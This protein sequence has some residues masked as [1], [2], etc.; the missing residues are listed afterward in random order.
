MALTIW[1]NYFLPPAANK[2]F[3]RGVASYRLL[4][5]ASMS[6]CNLAAG[7]S[8]PA[9][10]EAEIIFGQ[11]DP[12]ALFD[13]PKLKWVHLTSAGYDRYDRPDLRKSFA[14]RGAV[15]TNSSAVYEEPCAQHVLA[16][17]LALSRRLPQCLDEQRGDRSW[18]AAK[19]RVEAYRLVGQ[20]VVILSYG[21]IARRLIE[22]LLPFR[23]NVIAVRRQ[24]RDDEKVKTVT[25]RDLPSVL[26]LADH[27]VNILPGGAETQSAMG[28]LMFSKMKRGANF[29]NIGRGSTVDQSALLAALKSEQL[30]AAYLDV[31]DPEPLP[32]DHPLW[33]HPHCW[34]TPHTAGGSDDEFEQLARHF[35]ENLG[36]FT[37]GRELVNRVI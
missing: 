36:R 13:L 22:M 23:M 33:S 3:A 30:R 8:D 9:I 20:T 25:Q 21:S 28:S 35:L 18:S 10:R 2:I 14:D 7:A 4:K 24:V 12:A 26:A 29:Y 32:K 16:M 5:S 19:H 6:A 34:I 17:M 27:V 1:T 31:T 15:M 11:P 37:S